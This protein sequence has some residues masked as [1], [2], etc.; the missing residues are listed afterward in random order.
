MQRGHRQSLLKRLED[1]QSEVCNVTYQRSTSKM[2]SRADAECLCVF[3]HTR[4]H[5]RTHTRTHTHQ[6]AGEMPDA[7]GA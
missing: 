4:T 7:L 5:A 6:V 3:T 1:L 2:Q